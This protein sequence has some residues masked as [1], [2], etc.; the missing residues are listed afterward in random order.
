[1]NNDV[2][3]DEKGYWLCGKCGKPIVE[4]TVDEAGRHNCGAKT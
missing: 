2:W 4:K 3:D 1:M